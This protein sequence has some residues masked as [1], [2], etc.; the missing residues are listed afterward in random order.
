MKK[1]V[2]NITEGSMMLAIIGLFLFLNLQFA[3]MLQTYFIIFIPIPILIYTIRYGLKSGLI[4]SFGAVFLSIMMGNVITLFY[5]GGGLLVGIAYGYGVNSNKSNDWIL[6]VSTLI[7]A[8]SLFIETY[9]LAAFIGYD[10]IKD[11]ELLIESLKGIDGLVLPD[12][13]MNQVLAITP[14]VLILM[15]FLQA[16]ITHMFAVTLLK[17]LNIKIRKMK[18]LTQVIL[19]KWLGVIAMICLFASTYFYQ[20]GDSNLQIIASVIMFLSVLLII[21]DAFILI[22]IYGKRTNRKYIPTFAMLALILLPSLLIYAFI[23]LGLLDC[24]TDIRKRIELITL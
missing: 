21:S 2:R 16:L 14:I 20:S 11:T 6:I 3:G 8:I 22:T 12:N 17:R 18:P 10:L 7:N 1:Q 9:V 15:G 5:I 13:F 19:P 24:F 23:G 4:V